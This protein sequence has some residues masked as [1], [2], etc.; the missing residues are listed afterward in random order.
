MKIVPL[1]LEGVLLIEPRR[2][3]DERGVFCETFRVSALAEAG[4][5]RPFLQE[6][7]SIST[8]AGTVRG[9]HFQKQP[10]EQD[11]LVRAVRGAVLDVAVDI[12]PHSPTFGQHVAVELSSA[13][14]RQLLIPR[15]FAHGF[16]TLTD[17]CEV[18]YKT[19]QYYA[20]TAEGG[21]LWRDESIAIPW[22]VPTERAI[23]NARDA[24]WPTLAQWN[25]Q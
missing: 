21:I 4:F 12:R 1:E 7:H 18:Q 2:F 19:S 15:G 24:T 5:D 3:G 10:H 6:N 9:L 8:R 16:Q 20:P 17:D 11:K 23:V 25:A 22:P 14:W 13:N